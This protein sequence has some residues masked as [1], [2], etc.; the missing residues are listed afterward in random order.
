LNKSKFKWFKTNSN[1]S[2]LWP[3]RKVPFLLRK[4]EIKYGFEALKVVKNFIYRN[5]FRFGIDLELK[6]SKLSRL[7]FDRI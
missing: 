5:F 7:E 3:I 6:F 2:K 1:N 4:I